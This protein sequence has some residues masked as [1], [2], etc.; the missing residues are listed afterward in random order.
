VR[1]ESI[2]L[3]WRGTDGEFLYRFAAPSPASNDV[4]PLAKADIG[5]AGY[6][7][8]GQLGPTLTLS[9]AVELAARDFTVLDIDGA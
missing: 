7:A 2:V 4:A 8:S 9:E 5:A 3:R 6:L 1:E